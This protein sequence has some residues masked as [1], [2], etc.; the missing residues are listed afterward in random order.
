MLKDLSELQ[1]LTI[2]ATDGELGSA[3]QFYFDDDS[4]AIRYMV[5]KTGGWLAGKEVLISQY[6]I[7][8]TDWARDRW[9]LP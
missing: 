4:W 6:S 3:K 7:L 2:R 9:M 8:K 5:V 1:G